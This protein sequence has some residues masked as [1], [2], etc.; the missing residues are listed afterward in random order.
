MVEE[1]TTQAIAIGTAAEITVTENLVIDEA[2]EIEIVETETETVVIETEITVLSQVDANTKAEATI[3]KK[4]KMKITRTQHYIKMLQLKMTICLKSSS[5]SSREKGSSF[6]CNCQI[7][8][9]FW[10]FFIQ[11]LCMSELL[12]FHW[13]YSLL[14]H[15]S[16]PTSDFFHKSQNKEENLFKFFKLKKVQIFFFF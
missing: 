13:E 15:F 16:F 14:L 12:F 11:K 6:L 3:E 5:S 2:I 4:K 8:Y 1:D 9:Y 7:P 10:R